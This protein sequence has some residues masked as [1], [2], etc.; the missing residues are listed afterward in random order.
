MRSI[1]LLLKKLITA[2]CHKYPP[3]TGFMAFRYQQLNQRRLE[4]LATLNLPIRNKSILE[5]GAGIGDLTSFFLDRECSV[6]SVEARKENIRILSKRFPDVKTI[7]TDLDNI[8]HDI[9]TD[10]F[11]IVCS[12][13]LLYHLQHPA[14]AIKFMSNHCRDILL[15]ATCVSFG[16]SEELIIVPEDKR[17]KTQSFSGYGCRPTR[18]WVFENLKN[19]FEHVYIPYTQ[20]NHF[21]FITDWTIPPEKEQ[22]TRSVFVA[23]RR[24]LE[25]DTLSEELLQKQEKGS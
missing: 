24:K 14:E 3:T 5:L 18:K 23:S 15:L 16:E 19:H 13:G 10:Q 22:L 4:H 8:D 6:V 11:D 2:L 9:L 7:Q 1:K 12:Y 17:A 21:Q 25:L 20:P